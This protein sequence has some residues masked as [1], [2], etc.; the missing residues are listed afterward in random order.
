LRV[1]IAER[2]A[3]ALRQGTRDGRAFQPGPELGGLTGLKRHE[4]DTVIQAFG[5][6]RLP[7]DGAAQARFRRINRRSAEVR[8]PAR[9]GRSAGHAAFQ[10]LAQL[11]VGAS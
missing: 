4:L 7:A 3:H 11:K 6:R 5:Y 8:R 2:L 10:A 1:D 9:D